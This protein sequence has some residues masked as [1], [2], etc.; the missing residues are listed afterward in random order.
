ME[1]KELFK[2]TDEEGNLKVV[3]LL[4]YFT[5]DSNGKDY[6]VYTEGIEDAQG[7][8]I[9]NV[10][11]VVEQNEGIKLVGIEEQSVLGEVTKIIT[12]IVRS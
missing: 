3:E 11:E 7:N 6:L 4:H 10:L 12:E 5:L 8:V 1:N 2:I 9:V